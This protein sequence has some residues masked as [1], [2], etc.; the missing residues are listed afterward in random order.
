V[1]DAAV[2]VEDVAR[3]ADPELA[4]MLRTIP[5]RV[6]V[7]LGRARMP[8]AQAVDLGPGVVIELDRDA[9][10]PIELTIGGQP[11]A[12][13][14]LLRIEGEWAVRL[15]KIHDVVLPD[16]TTRVAAAAEE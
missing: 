4:S 3:S 15:E 14:R 11:F 7:E 10:E 2:P 12:S 13:G 1:S 16:G 9:D 8:L 6:G 5:V